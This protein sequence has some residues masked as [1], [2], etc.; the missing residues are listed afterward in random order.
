[1]NFQT[2]RRIL[3]FGLVVA[4]CFAAGC[5]N[6][7]PTGGHRAQFIVTLSSMSPSTVTAGG[8]PFVLTVSGSN[9]TECYSTL[10]W[11]GNQR[12]SSV[13]PL[14]CNNAQASFVIDASMITDPGIISIAVVDG[15]NNDQVSNALT[16]TVEPHTTTA[17]A[18]FGLYHY[19][20]TGFDTHWP[21]VA[22]GAFA[23]DANGNVTGEY[24]F[25]EAD[26]FLLFGNTPTVPTGSAG[27]LCTNGPTPN[28]GTV[29]LSC[30]CGTA[31]TT[32]AFTY[33]FV[34]EQGG[35]GRL[36]ESNDAVNVFGNG[37][38]TLSGSGTFAK[39][40]PDAAFNG[41]YVFGMTG[42]D[43]YADTRE[44]TRVG[45]IG[46]FAFNNGSLNGVVDLNDGGT[47]FS[48]ATLSVDTM[49][50]FSVDVYSVSS[51][52]NLN[53]GGPLGQFY[54]LMT[55]P[56][57]GFVVGAVQ[58]PLAP[59]GGSAPLVGSVSSQASPGAYSNSSLNAPLVLSASGAPPPVCCTTST[60]T[61]LGLASGFNS[62]TG[63]F[64]LLLDNVSGGAANLNQTVTGATYTVASNGRATVSYNLGGTASNYVCYLDKAN[65]GFILGLGNDA[66]FG[67][68]H[69]QSSGPFATTS[70]NGTFAGSTFLPL[71]P[72]APNLA[73]EITLNNGN[74]SANTPGGTLTGTYS[75]AP[76]GRG[77]ATVNL[78][79]LGGKDLVF[80]VIA[81]D[82]IVLMGSDNTTADS[83]TSM[84][85]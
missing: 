68:F 45:A 27:G 43:G 85:L 35:G 10:V 41:D 74:V 75:V 70:I 25:G 67:S 81:P 19:M 72:S 47:L 37:V 5:G 31:S 56:T 3:G 13:P 29:T 59:N 78:P 42:T 55:S 1:M 34:L 57:S 48:N 51:P 38:S 33:T 84:Q 46:Q 16:L 76:S 36:V 2:H 17:C 15:I 69:P 32:F 73:T 11:N 71:I 20:V 22:A 7:G 8:P 79:V 28:Q 58:S 26:G 77:T 60:S 66:E 65:E 12:I 63:T 53:L 50:P 80:Y 30:A 40:T 82:T 14:S 6:L 4:V 9:L 18:L 44:W 83:I 21:T 62:G 49:P 64:N 54:F 61:T 52:I 23:V 24:G 39:V